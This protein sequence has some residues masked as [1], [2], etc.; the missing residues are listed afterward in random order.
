MHKLSLASL[1]CDIIEVQR[2]ESLSSV[3]S[4]FVR[5][6]RIATKRKT[7]VQI[8]Q[9]YERSQPSFLRKRMVGGKRPRLPVI[10]GSTGPRWSQTF[11]F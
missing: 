4:N 10:L 1:T 7:C 2:I 8:F 11:D 3:S 5:V 6:L 9:P